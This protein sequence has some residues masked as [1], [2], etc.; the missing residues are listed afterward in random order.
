[1]QTRTGTTRNRRAPRPARTRGASAARPVAASPSRADA[2]AF[3]A[4]LE[5]VSRDM[6]ARVSEYCELQA[7]EAQPGR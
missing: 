7:S 5:K 3:S 1:M 6:W 2:S 4:A